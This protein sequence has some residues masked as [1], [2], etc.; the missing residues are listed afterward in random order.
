[1]ALLGLA[2]TIVPQASATRPVHGHRNVHLHRQ[3][4]D[5][6]MRIPG[7]RQHNTIN[8]E[9]ALVDPTPTPYKAGE[10]INDKPPH[11]AII[12]PVPGPQDPVPAASKLPPFEQFAS[13]TAPLDRSSGA[14]SGGG[15]E[16]YPPNRQLEVPAFEESFE[17]RTAPLERSS[18][19]GSGGGYEPYPPNR[20]LDIPGFEESFETRT[21]PLERSSGAGSGG[22][23]E[24]Y[25]PNRQLA[26][27]HNAALAF[28]V[29]AIGFFFLSLIWNL[30]LQ[31][32]LARNQAKKIDG[33][34]IEAMRLGG[35][36]APLGFLGRFGTSRGEHAADGVAAA[37][38]GEG[39]WLRGA[40]ANAPAPAASVAA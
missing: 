10:G 26:L 31:V 18:G 39:A 33:N 15:Y 3:H 1:M 38:G 22:G 5:E 12:P 14:G 29:S 30:Y 7:H 40:N 37:K 27:A 21:A 28:F 2:L 35:P 20:Q 9:T 25:P 34:A 24:P 4:H 11:T 36:P 6:A 17:T 16:P 19:A 8:S 13:R 23:Y 32:G